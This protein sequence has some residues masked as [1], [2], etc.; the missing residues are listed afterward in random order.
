MAMIQNCCF[1]DGVRIDHTATEVDAILQFLDDKELNGFVEL[2][3]H[4]GGLALC[5]MKEMPR[6]NY[7]GVTP[8]ISLVNDVTIL[9]ADKHRYTLILEGD[10]VSSEIVTQI[11][12]WLTDRWPILFYCDG[13]NKLVQLNLY[14][15]LV[16]YG[17]FLGVHDYWNKS[18][19]I[20][21]LPDYPYGDLQPDVLDMDI[22]FLK[23]EFQAVRFEPLISTRIAILQRRTK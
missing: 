18:R 19:I 12:N 11:N 17:D 8:H 2:G 14:R 23:H 6:L 3:M 20:D 10:T 22:K 1:T 21:D 16:R 15:N 9:K 7:L 4:E 13:D 5:I